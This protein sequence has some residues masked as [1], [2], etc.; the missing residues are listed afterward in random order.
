MPVPSKR[1]TRKQKDPYTRTRPKGLKL[2]DRQFRSLVENAAD[3]SLILGVDGV[4]RYLS[5]AVVPILGYAPEELIGK[6]AFDFINPPDQQR[7]LAALT[8][9][10]SD[11]ENPTPGNLHSFR[12]KHKDGSWRYLE[13]INSRLPRDTDAFD[14]VVNARDVTERLVAQEAQR[15]SGAHAEHVGQENRGVAEIGRIISSTS[16]IAEVYESFAREAKKLIEFDRVTI[17]SV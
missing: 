5:P 12:F 15:I 6:N 2:A 16:D 13:A 14:I 17:L 11:P 10:A 7:V 4:I 8:Q 1:T 9:V 3:L